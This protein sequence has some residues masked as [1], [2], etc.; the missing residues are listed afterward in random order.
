MFPMAK[1]NQSYLREW[2]CISWHLV[3][4]CANYSWEGRD[5]PSYFP[6]TT[7]SSPKFAVRQR[8]VSGLITPSD[9][10]RSARDKI[11]FETFYNTSNVFFL[12][13]NVVFGLSGRVFEK[14]IHEVSQEGLNSSVCP[15][16]IHPMGR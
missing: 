12:I 7:I 9:F 10:Q 5:Y 2:I 15:V 3:Q 13:S 8:V 16:K 14:C 4:H 1:L 11:T 6:R